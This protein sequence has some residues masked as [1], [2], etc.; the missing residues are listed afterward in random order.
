MGH[1]Y[2]WK[3]SDSEERFNDIGALDFDA[4]EGCF[5]KLKK[6]SVLYVDYETLRQD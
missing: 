3:G 1:G 5:C 2:F 4:F 6:A